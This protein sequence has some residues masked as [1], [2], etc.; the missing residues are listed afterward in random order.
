M[1]YYPAFAIFDEESGQF[2]IYF[3]DFNELHSYAF[4]EEDIELDAIDGLTVG[5]G[6]YIR[7]RMPVP[8]PSA[9]LT[10]DI[11]LKLPVLTCLKIELH[12]AMLQAGTKKADLAKML[13]LKGTQID[14]LLDTAYASKVE[15]LEQALY[16][17]GYEVCVSVERKS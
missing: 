15:T 7:E 4:T 8:R 6:D 13:G 14:R 5:I 16:L 10:G 1:F 9:A 17:L 3:R 12:N 2:E 11:L